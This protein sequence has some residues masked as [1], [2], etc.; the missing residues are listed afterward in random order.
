[1]VIERKKKEQENKNIRNHSIYLIFHS[2]AKPESEKKNNFLG[3]K[4]I[5][6]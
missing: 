5:I 2:Q 1:M 3:K 4:Y 6:K